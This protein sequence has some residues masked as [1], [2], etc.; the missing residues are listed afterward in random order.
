MNRLALTGVLSLGSLI[1]ILHFS[2]PIVQ[3]GLFWVALQLSI[4]VSFSF[5]P[6]ALK[7]AAIACSVILV[8]HLLW[9]RLERFEVTFPTLSDTIAPQ[10]CDGLTPDDNIE[11]PTPGNSC[12][13][14]SDCDVTGDC[15]SDPEKQLNR[16]IETLLRDSATLSKEIEEYLLVNEPDKRN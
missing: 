14:T 2:D 1:P 10:K 5:V 7:V 16:K 12:S 15:W 6:N 9:R 4:Q 8:I 13:A 3:A 11:A